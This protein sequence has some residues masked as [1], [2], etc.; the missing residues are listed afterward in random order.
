MATGDRVEAMDRS[1]QQLLDREEIRQE[2][3]KRIFAPVF[4]QQNIPGL[5]I[6]SHDYVG[7]TYTGDDLTS[8]VYKDGGSGGTTVATLTLAYS[9][10]KLQSVTRS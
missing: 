7:L 6:P 3:G 4:V 10:G 2:S 9:G 5:D 8:V 1:A